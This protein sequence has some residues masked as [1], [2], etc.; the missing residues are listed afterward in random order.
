MVKVRIANFVCRCRRCGG[1][2]TWEEVDTDDCGYVICFGC[3]DEETEEKKAAE[4]RDLA[5]FDDEDE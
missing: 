1:N 5:K 2:F 4:M 3:Q